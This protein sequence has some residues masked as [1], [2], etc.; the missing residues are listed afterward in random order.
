MKKQGVT[1][2]VLILA[3]GSLALAQTPDEEMRQIKGEYRALIT[4]QQ[5][6]SGVL[7]EDEEMREI[8]RAYR[9][10]RLEQQT[11]ALSRTLELTFVNHLRAGMAAEQDVHVSHKGVN[12]VFRA[13]AED[14]DLTARLYASA[15]GK[16]HDP[17]NPDAVGPFPRGVPLK[18]SL[19]DWLAAKGE[20][21]VTCREGSA[22]LS[23]RFRHLV[24]NG[25]YTLWYSFI[26]LP[27]TSPLTVM[28][29]PLGARDGSQNVLVADEEG[30]AVYA[31]EDGTCLQ[32]ATAQVGTMLALNYHSDGRTYGFDPGRFGYNVHVQ[33]FA[34]LPSEEALT[35]AFYVRP[36][37]ASGSNEGDSDNSLQRRTR[38][39]AH[40]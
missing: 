26:A 33:L 15:E 36:T 6:S 34:L 13:S 24:P 5:P 2:L 22:T 23:A 18:V 4:A 12:G 38:D 1:I 32:L 20:A 29:L 7:S 37:S 19:G 21:T 17:T 25:V 39:A 10:F 30:N 11:E 8:K 31:L 28:N 40:P 9:A 16:R 35:D 14:T 3:W 27:P